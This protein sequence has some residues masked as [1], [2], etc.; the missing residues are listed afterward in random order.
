MSLPWGPPHAVSP[1]IRGIRW[2]LLFAGIFYGI[3]KQRVYSVMEDAYREDQA[4]KKIIRDKQL[5]ILK[6]KIA[7]EEREAVKLFEA[8]KLF[9]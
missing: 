9:D 8:G 7:K 3:G 1:L 4:Q 5:A 2:A 6:E